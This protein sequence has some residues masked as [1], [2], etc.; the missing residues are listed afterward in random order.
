MSAARLVVADTSPLNYLVWI[1][2]VE[3]LRELFGQVLVPQAVWRE[4]YHP[5]APPAVVR[6]REVPPPWLQVM[7]VASVDASLGLGAGETE[8]ISLALEKDVRMILMDER[9]G[10]R[11]A[12][13]RGLLTLGTLNLID[14]ADAH[15]LLDGPQ[16]LEKL[17]GTNFRAQEALWEQFRAQ[18]QA[19][20]DAGEEKVAEAPTD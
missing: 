14:L 1:G 16:A 8:A 19:R 12:R 2:A 11:A 10:R 9:K 20:R 4:L 15:G 18:M 6:W 13:E 5:N 3:V 17:R 7:E